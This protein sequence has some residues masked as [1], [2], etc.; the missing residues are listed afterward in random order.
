MA[1]T[2]IPKGEF[3][4]AKVATEKVMAAIDIEEDNYRIGAT[5]ARNYIKV[6]DPNLNGRK[7]P[8][9]LPCT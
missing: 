5:K 4:D 3:V 2:A 1:P 6:S 8:V 7:H 9:Y